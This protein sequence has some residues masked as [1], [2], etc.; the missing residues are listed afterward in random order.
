M[1]EATRSIHRALDEHARRTGI[2]YLHPD[3]PTVQLDLLGSAQVVAKARLEKSPGSRELMPHG[4]FLA[5]APAERPRIALAVLVEH[6]GSGAEGAAP[7]ARQILAHF[8]GLDRTV[9]PA[10]SAVPEITDLEAED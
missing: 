1:S 3:E 7:V 6:A 9:A 10:P 8:F 4:W 2:P 5:F